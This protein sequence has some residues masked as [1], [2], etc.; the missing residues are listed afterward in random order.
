M[1]FSDTAGLAQGQNSLPRRGSSSPVLHEGQSFYFTAAFSPSWVSKLQIKAETRG[2]KDGRASFP[3]SLRNPWPSWC[4]QKRVEGLRFHV[5]WYGRD[6]HGSQELPAL[7]SSPL[8]KYQLMCMSAYV[9]GKVQ[10]ITL[11]RMQEIRKNKTKQN[12]RQIQSNLGFVTFL[13]AFK[14]I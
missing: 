8:G 11:N 2:W 12:K 5:Q 14:C 9:K 3:S 13:C 7:Q 6:H 1:G 4:V 10:K